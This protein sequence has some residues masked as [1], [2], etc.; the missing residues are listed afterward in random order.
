MMT[1]S[2][3][4]FS[5]RSRSTDTSTCWLATRSSRSTPT[6]VTEGA[7]LSH[8]GGPP[9]TNGVATTID[10]PVSYTHLTLPT[11]CSV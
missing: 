11:I 4:S 6:V 1:L 9:S 8:A 2:T 5:L 7:P 10:A 3:T